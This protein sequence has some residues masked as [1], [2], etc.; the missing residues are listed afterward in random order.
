MD[1]TKDYYAILGALPSAEEVVI[2]AAYKA[3]AQ[4]YHPDRYE[5][6]VEEAH[7]RMV[8]INEAYGVLSDHGSRKEYDRLRGS[9]AQNASSYFDEST[10]FASSY[11]PLVHDWAVALTYYPDLIRLESSLSRISWRLAFAYK[12]YLLESKK[13]DERSSIAAAM[14]HQFLELYFGTNPTIVRFAKHL[15]SKGNKPAAK[16]LNDAIRV[17]GEPSHPDEI[18]KRIAEKHGLTGLAEQ[19]E[20]LGAVWDGNWAGASVLLRNG[21]SPVGVWD[22]KGQSPLDLARKRGDREMIQLLKSYGAQ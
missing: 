19:Q 22:E 4:R 14:E 8:E 11:D 20:L 10:K 12:A 2:R 15:I 21:V 16:S 7:K 1:A 6:P 17:L 3:L 18:I 13:F 9:E 5:G